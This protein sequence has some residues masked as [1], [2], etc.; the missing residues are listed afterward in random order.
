M[1]VTFY[2]FTKRPNSTARPTGGTSLTSVQLKEECSFQNPVLKIGNIVSGT[3]IPSAFNYVYIPLWSR[4]Y[5]IT[6]WKYINGI[7]ECYLSV[8][9]LASF[10]TSIGAINTYIERCASASDGNIIDYFY[11]AKSNT[12]ITAVNA[13]CSWYNLAYSGFTAIL[14]V[15][16][17][18]TTYKI[19]AV[20]YYALTIQ[21]LKNIMA[22][23]F[24]GNI[25]TAS[26]I[27][28]IGEG[29]YKSLFN[30]FQYIVSCMIFPFDLQSF[31]GASVVQT[32]VKVGYWDTGV[33][34]I[35]MESIYHK[36]YISATIP[37]HPQISR[38]AYLNRAPYTRLTLYV[39]PFGAIPIDTNIISKGKYLYCPYYVDHITGQITVR[40]N[41]CPS[42][43]DLQE[44]NICTER[45][46]Q[47]GVPIQLAQVMADYVNTIGNGVSA[48]SSLITG[49]ISG[50]ISSALNAIQCQ[51]PTVSTNGANGASMEVLPPPVVMVEN[52]LITDEDNSEFGKPLCANRT[53]STL[54]GY[55][56]CANADHAFG[57][58]LSENQSINNYM[59]NGFFYD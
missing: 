50:A 42:N 56:K 18:D 11:P 47:I 20:T 5:Y 21:E 40:V 58:T 45:T 24:S 44:T 55:I 14:G 2:N 43:Q 41:T 38:G 23:L 22:Y 34:G 33:N 49:N 35:L 28:E 53:I 10:K 27:T 36:G 16:N 3:F 32:H 13:T 15:I 19:G 26:S 30:P 39:P 4:Y 31:A 8:D 7:W 29:L 48:V 12:V 25:Y 52:L 17:N 9:V 54:S 51:M 46:S 1:T 59:R 37:D 57:G 6:D